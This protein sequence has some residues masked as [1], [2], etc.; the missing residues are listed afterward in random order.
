MIAATFGTGQVAYS[1]LWFFLFVIEIWLMFTVFIDIF[2]SDDLKGWQKALWVVA[3]LVFPLLGILLYLIVR[4]NKMRAHQIQSFQET[5]LAFRRYIQSVVGQ[6]SSP[7][8]EL[9]RLAELRDRGELTADEYVRL[10]ERILGE[11]LHAV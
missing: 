11:E 1:I 3:V 9:Y 10:K 2:R 7:A 8:E 6:P 5:E 4:G